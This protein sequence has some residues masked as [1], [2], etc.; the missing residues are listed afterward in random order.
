MVRS[1]DLPDGSRRERRHGWRTSRLLASRI[2]QACADSRLGIEFAGVYDQTPRWLGADAF[3]EPSRAENDAET[4]AREPKGGTRQRNTFL[5]R[6]KQVSPCAPGSTLCNRHGADRCVP[7][8]GKQRLDPHKPVEEVAIACAVQVRQVEP[9]AEVLPLT[10]KNQGVGD[11]VAERA[12]HRR[13]QR[14]DKFRR[15]RVAAPR[16]VHDERG[17]A[18]I[19]CELQHQAAYR[20]R[21]H[22]FGTDGAS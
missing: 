12:I 3:G 17:H 20:E 19:L 4:R 22:R 16:S 7:E 1:G 9:G 21:S 2:R 15:Q 5:A 6:E 18:A 8:R 14:L 11:A 13:Q 10:A